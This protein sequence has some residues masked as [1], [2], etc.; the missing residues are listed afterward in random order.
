MEKL[1]KR[2]DQVTVSDR[3]MAGGQYRAV[4]LVLCRKSSS[5]VQIK[6]QDYPLIR[7]WHNQPFEVQQ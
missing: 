2:A 1:V 6:C 3:I 5:E 7:A 4:V